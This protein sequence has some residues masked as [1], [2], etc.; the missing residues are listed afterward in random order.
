MKA[1][2]SKLRSWQ[3][4]DPKGEGT[5]TYAAFLKYAK[6]LPDAEN[7]LAQTIKAFNGIGLFPGGVRCG[8]LALRTE[9]CLSMRYS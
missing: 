4:L 8:R 5:V 6:E 7:E 9:G 1:H 3:E 2:F